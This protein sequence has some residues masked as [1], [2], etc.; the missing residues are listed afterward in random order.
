MSKL[1]TIE[2]EDPSRR[3]PGEGCS[4]RLNSDSALVQ[5][6][7]EFRK[8]IFDRAG[9]EPVQG[10]DRPWHIEVVRKGNRGDLVR[11]AQRLQG[12]YVDVSEDFNYT[13][14]RSKAFVLKTPEV[15]GYGPTHITIAYYPNG[16]P[17]YVSDMHIPSIMK[18]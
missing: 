7:T 9:G 5:Y 4:K 8:D 6:L 14:M 16:V 1:L 3:L 11:N 10:N 2:F 17:E 15:P 18:S 12:K 13:V